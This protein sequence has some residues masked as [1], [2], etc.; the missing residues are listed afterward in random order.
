MANMK[1]LMVTAGVAVIMC[2]STLLT[3]CGKG[4]SGSSTA[5]SKVPDSPQSISM[6]MGVHKYFP[7]LSLNTESVYSQIYNACYTYGDVSAFVV[8]GDPYAVCSYNIAE[9]DKNIDSAKRKQIASSNTEQI[10]S[11]LSTA[12]A[13]TP[14]IDTLSAISKSA[15]AL[16][17]T[18]GEADLSMIIYDSGVSTTSL[19]NFATQNIIDEPVDSIVSQLESYHAIPDLTGID[20]VWIGLGQTCGD[21]ENLTSNY[22]YKLQ[23]RW[24]AILEAGGAA[25]VTFDKT[26]LTA[27]EYSGELPECSTV[28]VVVDSLELSELVTEDEMPEVIKWDGNSN[29]QFLSDSAEFVDSETAKSELEPIADYLV[30]HPEESVYIFGMTATVKGGDL[31]IDL[32]KDRANTCKASLIA[33]GVNEDQVITVGLGQ[34][35]NPLRTSDVD[36]N[37]DQIE[38][39][40]QKNRAVIFVKNGSQLADTLLAC[41]DSA[42]EV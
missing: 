18:A 40:A 7:V 30:A 10:M 37:G 12:S 36:E 39:S 1:K 5:T 42:N 23:E 14:E 16:H 8:D 19:L 27:E 29:I 34:L 21:Q 11:V 2:V 13:K 28:P 32:A 33:S 6:V 4:S 41:A 38:E 20:V 9:P 26:P 35:D 22:K 25:S 17:S 24:A 3:G 15:D 31:G